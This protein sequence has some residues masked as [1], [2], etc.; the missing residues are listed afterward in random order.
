M[1]SARFPNFNYDRR[2][3]PADR[4]VLLLM[5]DD[6]VHRRGMWACMPEGY[7]EDDIMAWRLA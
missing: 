2:A 1:N 5:R 6:S 7:V 4:D 3:C